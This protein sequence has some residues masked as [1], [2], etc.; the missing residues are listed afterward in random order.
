[1][2]LSG[3]NL[4]F[5]G[6]S[7]YL[8]NIFTLGQDKAIKKWDMQTGQMIKAF[9]GHNDSIRKLKMM[10]DGRIISASDDQ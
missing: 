2:L 6:V 5:N 3:G 8:F 10:P 9:Y 4:S 1:V 7:L